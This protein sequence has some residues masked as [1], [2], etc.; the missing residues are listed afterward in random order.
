[1]YTLT[2]AMLM[3]TAIPALAKEGFTKPP[4]I[5]DA[6][7]RLEFCTTMSKS[8]MLLADQR[9]KGI[10]IDEILGRIDWAEEETSDEKKGMLAATIRMIVFVYEDDKLVTIK[11]KNDVV[12]PK[13]FSDRFLVRCL[14]DNKF[15]DPDSVPVSATSIRVCR[16]FSRAGTKLFTDYQEGISLGI[17]L[18]SIK[19]NAREMC[20]EETSRESEAA[21]G[22]AKNAEGFMA[23]IAMKLY[24]DGPDFEPLPGVAGTDVARYMGDQIGT[25][26]MLKFIEKPKK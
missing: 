5:S 6:D 7:A 4:P 9:Q 1:M 14:E 18:T 20:K 23:S 22:C 11:S 12:T 3:I 13:R 16:F 15:A 19:E 10:S 26:C 8:A 2:A 17:V 25:S 21:E 24:R